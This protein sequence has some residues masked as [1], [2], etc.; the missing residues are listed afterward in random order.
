MKQAEQDSGRA[1]NGGKD[2]Q[3]SRQAFEDSQR[4]KEERPEANDGKVTAKDAKRT[5]HLRE[6]AG[7]HQVMKV[8]ELRKG[9]IDSCIKKGMNAADAEDIAIKAF[10]KQDDEDEDDDKDKKNVMK[11][12]ELQGKLSD[13]VNDIRK[14]TNRFT[15]DDYIA[16]THEASNKVIEQNDILK[17]GFEGLTVKNDARL[18]NL[19][20][21]VVTIAES[22][23]ALLAISQADQEFKK[24][25]KISVDEQ[26][27]LVKGLKVAAP[28]E[29]TVVDDKVSKGLTGKDN[30][31]VT[32]SQVVAVDSPLDAGAKTDKVD[33][34]KLDLTDGGAVYARLKDLRKGFAPGSDEINR[35]NQAISK[36]QMAGSVDDAL[37]LL[38]DTLKAQL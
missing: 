27:E 38:G 20:K 16:I 33:E 3:V 26:N 23:G 5:T 19:E 13:L 28:V 37:A 12:L 8:K 15:A 7:R 25:L 36:I 9:L 10:P 34:G 24:G 30:E 32:T 2:T 6:P 14:A 22:L 4:G 29:T 11:G 35:A 17:K 31:A 21:A 18:E 1:A